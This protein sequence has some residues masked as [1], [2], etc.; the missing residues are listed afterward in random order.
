MVENNYDKLEQYDLTDGEYLEKVVDKYAPL[1]GLFLISFSILEHDLNLSI[2]DILHDD[3]HETGFVIIE[4]LTTINKI[5]LFYKMYV[6]LEFFKDKKNKV[7]LDKIRKNL[8]SLNSFRNNI[9]H[10]DWQTI[11]KDRFVRTKIVI[12]NKE[13]CVKFKKIDVSTKIIKQRIKEID[14]LTKQIDRY[15]ETA[16]QF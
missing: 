4:K 16:F 10:A 15:M 12:D 9:V 5:D 2:A 1:V 3:C 13:G 8:E 14:A 6:R 11:T 7:I